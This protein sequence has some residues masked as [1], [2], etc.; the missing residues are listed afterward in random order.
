MSKE[1]SRTSWD[2]QDHVGSSQHV[3]HV[4]IDLKGVWI[5]EQGEGEMMGTMGV[6]R[7]LTIETIRENRRKIEAVRRDRRDAESPPKE[8]LS[9]RLQ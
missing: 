1:G 2:S 9:P 4:K 5:Y 7:T 3:V 8:D 6:A